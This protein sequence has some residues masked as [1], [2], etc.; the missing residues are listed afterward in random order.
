MISAGLDLDNLEKT[1]AIIL[2]ELDRVTRELV[3]AGEMRR[4]C[5]YVI[6][7]MDLSLENSEHQM[8]WVGE[9]LLGYGRVYDP[10]YVKKQL[11]K[12][13][14]SDVRDVAR[15]FLRPERYNVALISPLKKKDSIEKLLMA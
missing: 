2:R 11:A 8:M 3:P 10:S 15:E 6:G 14:A 5:D 4:A 7:Q 13:R 1:L 9:N 12:V